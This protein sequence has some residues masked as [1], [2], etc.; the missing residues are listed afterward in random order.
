MPKPPTY[1]IRE[2]EV[3]DKVDYYK[4]RVFQHKTGWVESIPFS[5]FEALPRIRKIHD[6]GYRACLYAVR[7]FED[8][9]H[10]ASVTPAFLSA[11]VEVGH[12]T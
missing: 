3:L 1:S 2:Q 7:K 6:M 4:I 10:L 5:A 8:G 11:L 12:G 9:E